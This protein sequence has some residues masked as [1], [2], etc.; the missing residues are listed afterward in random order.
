MVKIS[1]RTERERRRIVAQLE[2]LGRIAIALA[3]QRVW[4]IWQTFAY[5]YSCTRVYIHALVTR[6]TQLA[7][8]AEPDADFLCR[9]SRANP[10]LDRPSCRVVNTNSAQER[11]REKEGVR[12]K[13]KK[14]LSSTDDSTNENRGEKK[15]K[16]VGSGLVSAIRFSLH[17]ETR[18]F[19]T[20]R[21]VSRKMMKAIR[22]KSWSRIIARCEHGVL[23]IAFEHVYPFFSPV[24]RVNEIDILI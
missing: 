6:C 24:H 21:G 3:P 20:L 9:S 12:R 4:Q 19:S 22:S 14:N 23:H 1:W 11:E 10:M 2:P 15:K 8:G 7:T 5:I 17:L 13:T 16:N 18:D